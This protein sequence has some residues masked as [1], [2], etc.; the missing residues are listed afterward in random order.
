MA[1]QNQTWAGPEPKIK[2]DLESYF[3]CRIKSQT[4]SGSLSE[5][6]LDDSRVEMRPGKLLS[7]SHYILGS[8]L[9]RGAGPQKV[10]F[11]FSEILDSASAPELCV[12]R[13]RRCK[14]C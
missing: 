7:R 3:P 13:T 5:E 8:G 10:D 1:H 4:L 6:L 14:A 12:E 11:V 9:A 2:C